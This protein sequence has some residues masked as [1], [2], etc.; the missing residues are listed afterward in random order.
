MKKQKKIIIV[1][2]ESI[3][4]TKPKEPYSV[5][6]PEINS[7]SP[8]LK[9]KGARFVSANIIKHHIKS[10]GKEKKKK[11]LEKKIIFL[12]KKKK[13]DKKTKIV[14]TIS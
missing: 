10:K 6:K 12:L 3:N 13:I 8:S 11:K 5:L 7:L 2:S 9:S 1:Y 14:K 4:N